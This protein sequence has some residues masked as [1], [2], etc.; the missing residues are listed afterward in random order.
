MS[1]AATQGGHVARINLPTDYIKLIII[2]QRLTEQID[3]L[4]C[5]PMPNVM[6]AL[7]Y[8]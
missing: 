7:P 8:I 4:E 5:G 2:N 6:V 3:I 1:A